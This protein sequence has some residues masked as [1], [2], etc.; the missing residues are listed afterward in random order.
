MHL[1]EVSWEPLKGR[2]IHSFS[3]LL[4]TFY[5]P[6]PTRSQDRAATGAHDPGLETDP[7][8][9]TKISKTMSE[10]PKESKD[11]KTEHGD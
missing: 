6:R 3:H 5:K 9:A 11:K 2:P 1:T 8:Q 4:N 7:K 10:G